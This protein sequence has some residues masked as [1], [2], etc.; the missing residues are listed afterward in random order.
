MSTQQDDKQG[1]PTRDRE[2]SADDDALDALFEATQDPAPLV[3][4]MIPSNDSTA[5]PEFMMFAELTRGFRRVSDKELLA[6]AR[7]IGQ[8]MAAAGCALYCFPVGGGRVEGATVQLAEEL[9]RAYGGMLWA[10]MYD[11]ID[12]N[13]R[14]VLRGVVID[15]VAKTIVARPHVAFLPP[16]SKGFSKSEEQAS[17]WESMQVQSAIS[18]AIRTAILH[19]LPGWFVGAAIAAARTG[20]NK[21]V[22]N[23]KTL[24]VVVAACLKEFEDLGVSTDRL[25]AAM[26]AEFIHWTVTDIEQ[27]RRQYGDIRANRLNADL[28]FPRLKQGDQTPKKSTGGL[29]PETQASTTTPV[30]PATSPPAAV[31]TETSSGQSTT[32]VPDEL[33]VA[34]EEFEGSLNAPTEAAELGRWRAANGLTVTYAKASEAQLRGYLAKL[35][36]LATK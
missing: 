2:R 28:A 11:K 22:L 20:Q 5:S 26:G 33:R 7:R 8:T 24:Q 16:A 19:A 23:G 18:K 1:K 21:A 14:V 25:E 32:T 35:K 31:P 12:D 13:G 3:P 10:V 6:A 4:I 17:R 9:A 30:T 15:G 29:A 36:A 27:L 34:I